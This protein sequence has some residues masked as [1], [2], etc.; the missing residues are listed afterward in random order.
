MTSQRDDL[1]AEFPARPAHPAQASFASPLAS[2]PLLVAWLL[3]AALLAWLIQDILSRCGGHFGYPMDDTYIHMAMARS[4]SQHSVWGLTRYGFTSSSSSPLFTLLLS[5][6]YLLTGPS[7]IAPLVM[8]V[9]FGLALLWLLDAA[10]RRAGVGSVFRAALLVLIVF[11]MPLAPETI[12]GME[13]VPQTLLSLLFVVFASRMLN[14]TEW[15]PREGPILCLVAALAVLC[16]YEAMALVAAAA[17]LFWWRGRR[18]FSVWLGSAALAPVACYGAYSMAQGWF[19][20]PNSIIAKISRPGKGLWPYPLHWAEQLHDVPAL[21]FLMAAGI[22]LFTILYRRRLSIWSVELVTLLLFGSTA[23]LHL[24]FGRVGWF[25][26]YE[27]YLVVLGVYACGL[28]WNALK[29][30]LWP[31][32]MRTRAAAAYAFGAAVLLFAF[33]PR[34][35]DSLWLTPY[36]CQNIHDQQY[37]VGEFLKENFPGETVILS[38]IGAPAFLS[39]SRIVDTYGLANMAVTK[40][41]LRHGYDLAFRRRLAAQEGAKIAAVFPAEFAELGGLPPEWVKAG[42]WRIPQNQICWSDTVTF[43]AV[44]PAYRDRLTA[45]LRTFDRR[46]PRGVIAVELR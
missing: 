2:W 6:I 4:F 25:F 35:V 23:L 3:F 30:P 18:V 16:R 22:V 43:F 37:Q 40:A 5:A 28:A 1:I 14:R 21:C 8:D 11:E 20:V 45:G 34:V 44:D 39:D 24:Q 27:A 29:L 31:G 12:A 19:P 42:T 9:V 46:L 36:A 26:R 32:F 15:G 17:T 7:E 13:H 38:D 33:V 41:K 10:F